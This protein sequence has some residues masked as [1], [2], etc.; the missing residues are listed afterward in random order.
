M[1]RYLYCLVR[2][3]PNPRTGEFVNY[4]AIVGDPSTGDWSVR[5]VSSERHV[6]KLA[7]RATRNAVHNFLSTLS[8]QIEEDRALA[9]TS[10]ESG[11]SESWLKALHHDHR[12]VVQLTPP[13]PVI[14]DNAEQALDFLFQQMI[15]DPVSEPRSQMTKTRV[16][17]ELRDVYRNASIGRQFLREKPELYVGG[18]VHTLIDFAIGNGRIVQL[19][20]GWSFQRTTPDEI[21]T[22]VKA[23]G[24]ALGRL[25]A[26]TD[27]AR[28]VDAQSRACGIDRGV[29]LEVVVASPKTNAQQRVYEEAQQVFGQVGAQVNTVENAE[30]VGTR[31]AELL[32]T[33]D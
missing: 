29:D 30:V 12:N 26:G 8:E 5:Q 9:E 16:L 22:E 3:V 14:A 23:W 2:C 20:Q 4:G 24:Y 33:A 28:I 7:D 1:S 27:D 10:G 17:A 25:R 31:A 11:L 13:T 6:Q 19:T 18:H 21:S 15:I 32:Q